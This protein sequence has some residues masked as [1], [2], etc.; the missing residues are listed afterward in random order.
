MKYKTEREFHK[1]FLLKE[2]D[3]RSIR[4]MLGRINRMIPQKVLLAELDAGNNM[5]E[6]TAQNIYNEVMALGEGLVAEGLKGAHI[7]IVSENLG[8]KAKM[9]TNTAITSVVTI[10]DEQIAIVVITSP[11]SVLALTFAFSSALRAQ[12]ILRFI[13]LPVTN[14]R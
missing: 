8:L 6:Y 1:D 9:I 5:V 14:E 12:G 4:E 11:S 2:G 3:Y 13:M 10:I 7:A